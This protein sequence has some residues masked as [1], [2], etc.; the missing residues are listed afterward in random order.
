MKIDNILKEFRGKIELLYGSQLANI[1]LYG[2]WARGQ[3]TEDSDIDIVVVIKGHIKPGEEID[4]M[5]EIITDL[6]LQH[7]VLLSVYPV[8]E[9]NY[10]DLQSPLLR[11]IR[12]EG[13]AA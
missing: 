13:L 8:S 11:N 5:I 2:S 3:A 9:K 12:R 7:G 1:I 10:T 4:R 6:N